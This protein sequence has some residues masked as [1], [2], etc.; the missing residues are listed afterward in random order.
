MTAATDLV[1]DFTFELTPRFIAHDRLAK[2][3]QLIRLFDHP[4]VGIG[5]LTSTNCPV[6]DVFREEAGMFEDSVL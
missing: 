2:S 4:Y 1:P 3:L 6:T 5:M